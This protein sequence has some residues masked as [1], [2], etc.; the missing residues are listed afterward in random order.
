MF[1]FYNSTTNNNI[2]GHNEGV[3]ILLA[4]FTFQKIILKIDEEKNYSMT[5]G[6][7]PLACQKMKTK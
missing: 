5:L 6:S 3:S 4:F 1:F 2:Q 7:S